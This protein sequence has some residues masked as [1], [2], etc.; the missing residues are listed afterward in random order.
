MFCSVLFSFFPL[1]F[2]I[3]IQ[4][5]S[6]ELHYELRLAEI[7]IEVPLESRIAVSMY[8]RMTY[9]ERLL[10]W[11]SSYILKVAKYL[12]FPSQILKDVQGFIQTATPGFC[13]DSYMLWNFFEIIVEKWNGITYELLFQSAARCN[14]H[15]ASVRVRN[16][17]NWDSYNSHSNA[18]SY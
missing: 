10:F 3:L 9:H 11:A 14:D 8:L 6:F 18:N 7:F 4:T 12:H 13:E 15:K 1:V 17:S 16:F 2:K 5:I